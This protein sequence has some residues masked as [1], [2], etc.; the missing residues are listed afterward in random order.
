MNCMHGSRCWL[1]V[2]GAK[3]RVIGD[4]CFKLDVQRWSTWH[5]DQETDAVLAL[6]GLTE[7]GHA[8]AIVLHRFPD[9]ENHRRIGILVSP[10]DVMFDETCQR[11]AQTFKED[12]RV[13]TITL[14]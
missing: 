14:E 5:E 6:I 3:G 11:L 1:R 8:R 9:S 10:K 13:Q 7:S 12:G 4:V 2:L